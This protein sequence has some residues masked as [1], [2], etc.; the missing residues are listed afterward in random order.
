MGR[1]YAK[2]QVSNVCR[3]PR[4][5]LKIFGVPSVFQPWAHLAPGAQPHVHMQPPR[6][7]ARG[8]GDLAT[9]TDAVIAIDAAAAR[10]YYYYHHR[11]AGSR[12]QLCC[13]VA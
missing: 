5:V 3:T 13:G 4:T 2:E 10:S 7:R 9:R 12:W 1:M 11:A 6:G 8:P